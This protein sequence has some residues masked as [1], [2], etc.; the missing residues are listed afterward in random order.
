MKS[1]R[2][3]ADSFSNVGEED[4]QSSLMKMGSPLGITQS[5]AQSQVSA[6]IMATSGTLKMIQDHQNKM[7]EILETADQEMNLGK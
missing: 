4:N 1:H 6:D 7:D 5:L 3:S 2:I